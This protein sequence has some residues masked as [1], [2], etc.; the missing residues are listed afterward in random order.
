M[1]AAKPG[2]YALMTLA[3][4]IGGN[5]D[6]CLQVVS[7]VFGTA[8][9]VLLYLWGRRWSPGAGLCAAALLGGLGGHVWYSRG[10]FAAAP[11]STL[12]LL[13]AYLYLKEARPSARAAL[14][15]G[16][17]LGLAIGVHYNVLPAA[18]AIL[19]YA[20]ARRER[21]ALAYLACGIALPLLGW[22]I[23]F[24]I[25]NAFSPRPLFDYAGELGHYLFETSRGDA[26]QAWVPAL[27][28]RWL[29]ISSGTGPALLLSAGAVVGA[30]GAR[31]EARKPTP[32]LLI[33]FLGP[34]MLVVWSLA[35]LWWAQV[36]RPVAD[37][38]PFLCLCGGIGWART[39]E[40]LAA[41]GWAGRSWAAPA[42]AALLF[43]AGFPRAAAYADTVSPYKRAGE[44][45]QKNPGA[46]AAWSP[47][48]RYYAPGSA[49]APTPD[50]AR[51]IAAD[52]R[53][54]ESFVSAAPPLLVLPF[55][56]F[57][58]RVVCLEETAAPG[59]CLRG[60]LPFLDAVALYP[61][62]AR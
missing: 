57:D 54:P 55:S 7:A 28:P 14:G 50:A 18:A 43:A 62:P 47:L 37:L 33:A 39:A 9:V 34:G 60:T 2:H 42:T 40:A 3:A 38:L 1:T 4:L 48:I 52:F 46:V 12:L 51:T 21:R 61:G 19:V 5:G 31:L 10:L 26:A 45:L 6:F 16:V 24:L 35:S 49:F 13:G 53:A 41:R 11:A 58:P 20:A 23:L 59:P 30:A 17:C 44:F 25:R 8:A 22:E 36:A 29:A 32:L 56:R 15:A 27:L